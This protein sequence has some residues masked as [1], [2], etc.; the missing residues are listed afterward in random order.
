MIFIS[1]DL[2]AP[3]SPSTAW[4]S[5]G[6]T[7]KPN[8]IEPGQYYGVV[9]KDPNELIA[10][11]WGPDWPNAST[12][13][14]PLFTLEGGWDLAR[15]DDKAFNEKVQAASVELDR[16]TQATM[17]QDLNTEMRTLTDGV[18]AKVRASATTSATSLRSAACTRRACASLPARTRQ[19]PAQPMAPR[20]MAS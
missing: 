4:I 14:P 7:V 15:V 12:V 8:P 10:G 17:W 13:I 1:V 6:I 2:P 19:I 11:G 9:F 3:F 20:C 18:S 5:P 16:A